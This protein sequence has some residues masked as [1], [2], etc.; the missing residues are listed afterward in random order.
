MF[1]GKCDFALSAVTLMVVGDE[2]EAEAHQ[3]IGCD[4]NLW[5]RVRNRGADG[6]LG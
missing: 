4:R 6:G 2:M 3:Q 1:P 5:R